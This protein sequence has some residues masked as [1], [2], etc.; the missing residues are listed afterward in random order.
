MYSKPKL[1]PLRVSISVAKESDLT[2]LKNEMN[3]FY[4][5]LTHNPDSKNEVVFIAR[6][7]TIGK[8][9]ILGFVKGRI[10][11][12]NK[13]RLGEVLVISVRKGFKGRAIGPKLLGKVN[14]YFIARRVKRAELVSFNNEFYMY[15]SNYRARAIDNDE[16]ESSIKILEANLKRKATRKNLLKRISLPKAT[17]APQ[18]IMNKDRLLK[19]RMK[20]K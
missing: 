8:K 10:I 6:E 1:T 16:L 4:T 12:E 20:L 18:N 19:N 11:K 2:E 9:R 17:I 5:D 14:S 3:S 15:R 13:E 7:N